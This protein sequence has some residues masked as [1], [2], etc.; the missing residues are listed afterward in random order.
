MTTIPSENAKVLQADW[1][2]VQG[3]TLVAGGGLGIRE[4]RVQAVLEGEGSARRL[5][6]RWGVPLQRLG[7]SILAPGWVNAHAHLELSHLAGRITARGGFPEWVSRLLVAKERT[8]ASQWA[9][10]IEWGVT[11]LLQ[12]GT[13]FV[14]DIDSVGASTRDLG[15]L[16]IR[17]RA[18]RE[19]LDVHRPERT[20]QAIAGLSTRPPAHPLRGVGLAPHAGFSVSPALLA[21]LGR[22]AR[23][24]G[25]PVTQHWSETSEEVRWMLWGD[26]P[27]AGWLGPSPQRSGLDLLQDCGLLGPQTSLVHGNHP[28]TGEPERL[29]R[30]G[31]TLV[32]CPGSHRYFDRAPFPLQAFL[33]AGVKVALGTDSWASNADLH[34]GREVALLRQSHPSID[35]VRAWSMGTEF[36]ALAVGMGG[37][38]GRLQPG[39]FADAAA[40]SAS[41]HSQADVLE[42]LT[43]QAPM[44]SRLWIGGRAAPLIGID[45]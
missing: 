28:Q 42:W 24:W 34:M 12:S 15:A 6:E 44:A 25:L 43:T 20:A 35:A 32:H 7:A 19:S 30:A 1:L 36:G 37:S 5:A 14:A 41:G 40:Y 18:Y 22:K 29:A 2:V 8:P 17:S 38:I 31:T 16:P 3:D 4:G 9:R 23:E 39:C 26:G 45:A 27:L 21:V 10:S 33:Q 13:T 11:R